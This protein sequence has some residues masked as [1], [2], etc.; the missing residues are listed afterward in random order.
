M[1]EMLTE[2]QIERRL[3]NYWRDAFTEL[4]KRVAVSEDIPGLLKKMADEERD[5]EKALRER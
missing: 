1:A 4:V 5:Y 2:V 3:R